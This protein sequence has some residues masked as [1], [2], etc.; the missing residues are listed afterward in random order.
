M[1]T[2][3]P[4]EIDATTVASRL[5]ALLKSGFGPGLPRR[6]ADRFIL[7]HAVS[8]ALG[9][10]ET[11]DER[12]FTDRL[13]GWLA[14][15]GARLETDAVTLRRALVDDGFVERDGRGHAYRRSRAHERRFVFPSERRP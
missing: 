13:T 8:S 6:E 9:D 11:L 2:E 15:H 14:E 10:D 4:R 12:A 1:T 7:L 5:R 3:A